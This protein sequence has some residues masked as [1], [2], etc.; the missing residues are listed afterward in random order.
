[1]I[2]PESLYQ[3]GTIAKAHGLRGEVVFHFSDDI[4]DTADADH[5]ILG[6]DGTLVPFFI[7]EYRFR[8]DAS[9]LIKFDGIHSVEQAR[10]ILG[11]PVYIE[12]ELAAE[13]GGEQPQTLAYF[14]GFTVTDERMGLLGHIED[15]DDQTENWLFLVRTADGRQIMLPAHEDL[16]LDIDH[17]QRAIR[18]RLPEGILD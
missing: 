9:A 2:Q 17:E 4:F 1:M 10:P 11:C 18:M 3:I 16:I 12:K 8:G 7:E 13:R 6:I 15:V 5:L 14:V